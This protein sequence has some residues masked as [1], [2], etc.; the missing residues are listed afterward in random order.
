[1]EHGTNPINGF[2]YEVKK[3]IGVLSEHGDTSKEFNLISFNGAPAKYDLRT[4]RRPA[5]DAARM[6]KGISL[7]DEEARLLYSLLAKELEL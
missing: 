6:Y 5:G 4:W 1:M 7:T 2:K 3:R